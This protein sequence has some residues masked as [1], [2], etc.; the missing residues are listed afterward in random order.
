MPLA[1]PVTT[2]TLP[3]ICMEGTLAQAFIG[4][5]CPQPQFPRLLGDDVRQLLRKEQIRPFDPSHATRARKGSVEPIWP[6]RVEDGVAGAPDHPERCLAALERG[7][8]R[9]Q[10]VALERDAIT[11]E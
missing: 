10:W 11:V 8:D 6:R 1:P 2:T 7:L 5:L 9:Q 4:A 3:A